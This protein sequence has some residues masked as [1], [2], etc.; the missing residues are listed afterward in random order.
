MKTKE[1]YTSEEMGKIC[2]IST[3]TIERKRDALLEINTELDWFKMKTKPYKYSFKMMGEFLSPEVFELI[4]DNRQQARA[5]ECMHSNGTL[6]QHLSFLEWNYFITIS[7][8]DSLQKEKCF[9]AMHEFYEYLNAYSFDSTNRIFFT[10]EPFANRTGHHNHFVLKVDMNKDDLNAFMEKYLP[11]GIIDIIP[12]DY[13]KA[14][15]FYICKNGK[16]EEDWDL[17]G[18]KLHEEG[19]ML[20]ALKLAA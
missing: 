1:W 16:T 10:T 8:K 11:T 19:C 9:S 2:R 5:I 14:G 17:M 7:Y 12:Y 3:R 18:N 4:N 6:E 15:I 13:Q 20:K